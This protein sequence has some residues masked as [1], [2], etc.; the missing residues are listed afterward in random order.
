MNA[1]LEEYDWTF[2]TAATLRILLILIIAWV[3]MRAAKIALR[4]LE[5]RMLQRGQAQG[6]LPN[7]SLRRVETLIRLLQQ[8]ALI[9]LWVVTILIILREIG[10]EI[11][12]ILASA[13]VVGVA[14]GFG[15]QNLVRDLIAGFFMILENQVRVGDVA[16]INGTG[17]LV[18]QINFRTTVLRDMSGAVHVF[19]NGS[20]T[21]ISNR[22]H[23]W[24]AYV[25]DIGVSYKENPDQVMEI[26][27]AVSREMRE[28]RA[29]KALMLADI[30]IFGVDQFADSAVIIK[31]R[32]K[33]IPIKQ[34]EVGREYLRRLK[35]AF[36]RAGIE[37]PFP[38]RTI[39][40]NDARKTADQR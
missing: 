18:E 1:L 33:T 23:E 13:G 22:T 26:M 27:R 3:A 24:S 17:G 19:P 12:P 9:L 20:I 31:A 32:L 16:I 37:I 11:A 15:A 4:R 28:D 21:T 39:Y 2:V 30:E 36:D 34:W 40:L 8:G 5:K 14:L 25:L 7:E 35:K 38:H 10:V 6:E 29:Y